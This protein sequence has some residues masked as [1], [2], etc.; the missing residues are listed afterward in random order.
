MS[1]LSP[2]PLRL[3][4]TVGHL[5]GVGDHLAS[6][7]YGGGPVDLAAGEDD[8]VPEGEEDEGDQEGSEEQSQ[9][10][11]RAWASSERSLL[12]QCE[13]IGQSAG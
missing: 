4:S 2:R 11:V 5:L 10:V 6:Q 7:G 13:T 8:V 3:P 12:S 1:L 9:T